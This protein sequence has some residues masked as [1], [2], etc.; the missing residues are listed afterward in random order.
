MLL[1]RVFAL[2][3]VSLGMLITVVAGLGPGAVHSDLW[4]TFGLFLVALIASVATPRTMP[5]SGAARWV[6]TA[7]AALAILVAVTDL[8]TLWSNWSLASGERSQ[9]LAW[10][11][12]SY[13]GVVLSGAIILAAIARPSRRTITVRHLTRRRLIGAALVTGVA[14]AAWVAWSALVYV[15]ANATTYSRLRKGMMFAEVQATFGRA[16]FLD[17]ERVNM[18]PALR[19]ALLKGR[20]NRGWDGPEGLILVSFG[21][22]GRVESATFTPPAQSPDLLD[23]LRA[24]VG[25]WPR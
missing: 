1:Q 4:Y 23:Q 2:V 8:P 19:Q 17:S 15:P 20:S 25:L 24:R 6:A 7:A 10:W 12:V 13:L 21:A 9:R 16:P 22:D 3:G 5:M 11:I 14:M 18:D